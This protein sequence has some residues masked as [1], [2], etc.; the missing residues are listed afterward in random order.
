MAVGYMYYCV[1]VYA[2]LQGEVLGIT[3]FGLAKMKE[4][5]LM[6]AS[7]STA[8]LVVCSELYRGCKN[9]TNEIAPYIWGRSLINLYHP[10]SVCFSQLLQPLVYNI[11]FDFTSMVQHTSAQ[12]LHYLQTSEPLALSSIS[13]SNLH[14]GL[15][16]KYNYPQ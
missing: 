13:N 3:R 9:W 10:T 16:S 14:I 4:S 15:Y 12:S 6:L 11:M 7:V 1:I 8:T 2:W 5:V